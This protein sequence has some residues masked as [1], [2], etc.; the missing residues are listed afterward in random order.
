[1][2]DN[3][4]PLI[5][6]EQDVTITP[7]SELWTPNVLCNPNNRCVGGKTCITANQEDT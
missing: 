3:E 1:M 5:I 6:R 2:F 4:A 7:L